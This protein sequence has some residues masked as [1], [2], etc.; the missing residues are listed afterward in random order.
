MHHH[1]GSRFLIDTLNNM[2]YCS[3]YWEVQKFEANAAASLN[4]QIPVNDGTFFQFI[5]DNVDHNIRTIDGNNTFHGMGIIA[6]SV[7]V[8]VESRR[9]PRNDIDLDEIAN[10]GRINITN[11][12]PY[13]V[14]CKEPVQFKPLPSFAGNSNIQKDMFSHLLWPVCSDRP[15]WSG[16]MQMY[17]S[18]QSSYPGPACITFMP[19]IDL[20]PSDM[21]CIH[22]TL[23]FVSGQAERYKR[24]PVLTFD[25]QLFQN[26]HKIISLQAAG[27]PLQRMFYD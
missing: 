3:S 5:A 22:S 27:S 7:P 9:I 10:L 6:S 24:T 16:F 13:K 1:F 17:E 4:T 2:G 25:Q 26:A 15:A 8:K 20:N 19:M 18:S 23:E 12:I 14:E 21:T 11:F